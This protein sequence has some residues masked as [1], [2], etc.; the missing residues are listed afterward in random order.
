M[1]PVKLVAKGLDRLSQLDSL[2]QREMPQSD[3]S[4]L[5]LLS[6]ISKTLESPLER[7]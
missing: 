7:N 6:I 5:L 3:S 4:Y 1:S 2:Y